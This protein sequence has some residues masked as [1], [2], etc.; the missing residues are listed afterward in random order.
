MY[1]R[2]VVL[3]GNTRFGGST[4]GL[5]SRLFR[6]GV[7]AAKTT[8]PEALTGKLPDIVAVVA[9]TLAAYGERLRAGDIIITGSITPPIFLERDETNIAHVL[10]P[11]DEIEVN[12]TWD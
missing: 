6:R 2:N 10:D 4:D 7:E 1:H 3:G 9:N 8:D 5:T 12:F 11:I